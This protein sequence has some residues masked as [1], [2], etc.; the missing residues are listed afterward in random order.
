VEKDGRRV[1]MAYTLSVLTC[2][3]VWPDEVLT[4]EVLKLSSTCL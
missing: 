4:A 2:L 1:C 3:S